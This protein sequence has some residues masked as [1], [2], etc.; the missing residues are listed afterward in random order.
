MATTK[1]NHQ[2]HQQKD[3]QEK[4]HATDRHAHEARGLTP[5]TV[6]VRAGH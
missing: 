5:S 6:G 3:T 1:D 2:G 4:D